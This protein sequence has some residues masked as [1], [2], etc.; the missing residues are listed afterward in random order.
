MSDNNIE[1]IFTLGHAPMVERFNRTLKELLNKYLQSTNSKTIT[2][3]LPKILNNY[4][5]SYH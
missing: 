2:N 1:I 5:S 4:N 3:V